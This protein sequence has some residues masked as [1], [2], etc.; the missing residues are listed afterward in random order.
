ML[1]V[2]RRTWRLLTGGCSP[3]RPGRD[4]VGV[5]KRGRG[6]AGGDD[7]AAPAE[8]R[9]ADCV[10]VRRPHQR[11]C[12]A[13]RPGAAV[14]PT[15]HAAGK[16]SLGVT[17]SQDGA[18]GDPPPPDRMCSLA[19]QPPLAG[20]PPGHH[21]RRPPLP[22]QVLRRRRRRRAGPRCGRTPPPTARTAAP[23]TSTGTTG[24]RG[25]RP[26]GPLQPP[27]SRQRGQS[28]CAGTSP[29]RGTGA[30]RCSTARRR[31]WP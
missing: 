14:A 26:G 27:L 4:E 20:A 12:G 17:T 15:A 29:Q 19:S 23:R 21:P 18:R 3:R 13:A 1:Y 10:Q 8:V 16:E 22:P 11:E 2:E 6:G 5:G 7:A 9:R 25:R 31:R 24:G 30:W 28:G